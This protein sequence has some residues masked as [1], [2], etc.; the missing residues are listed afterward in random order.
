MEISDLCKKTNS[1]RQGCALT[2]EEHTRT[3]PR[4]W[5]QSSILTNGRKSKVRQRIK[6]EPAPPV[7]SCKKRSLD[8][9]INRSPV[10]RPL[11][12][13]AKLLAIH[14]TPPSLPAMALLNSTFFSSPTLPGANRSFT[15]GRVPL[16]AVVD[17]YPPLVGPDL[18]QLSTL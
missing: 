3:K 18:M 13:R 9:A 16:L 15:P 12:S 11:S 8:T 10:D 1:H 6:L 4:F 14:G 5:D 17:R 2:R 7:R